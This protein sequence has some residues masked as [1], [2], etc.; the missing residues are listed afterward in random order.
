MPYRKNTSTTAGQAR[1]LAHVVGKAVQHRANGG[2]S[3]H[4]DGKHKYR[5]PNHQCQC[6]AVHK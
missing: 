2:C 4:S 5:G 3:A 1:H 6:G